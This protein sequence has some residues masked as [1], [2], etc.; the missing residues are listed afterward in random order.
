VEL[1]HDVDFEFVS[2]FIYLSIAQ[3]SSDMAHY[4]SV[5][6]L[7]LEDTRRLLSKLEL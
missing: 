5:V 2:L 7:F 4:V 6:G 1:R 3:E